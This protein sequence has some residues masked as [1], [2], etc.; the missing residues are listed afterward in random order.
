MRADVYSPL[1]T[2]RR[3]ADRELSFADALQVL[4][5]IRAIHRITLDEDRGL[6]AVSRGRVVPR[7][8]LDKVSVA[9]S[10]PEM[11]VRV[12]DGPAWLEDR[13]RRSPR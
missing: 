9:G 13:L 5:A 10:V 1:A 7:K 11:Q 3:H 8:F 12:D 2:H 6:D 4:R